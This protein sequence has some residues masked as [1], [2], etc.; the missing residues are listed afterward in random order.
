MRKDGYLLI[1]LAGDTIKDGPNNN[2]QFDKIAY[3]DN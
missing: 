2:V 3:K 1:F